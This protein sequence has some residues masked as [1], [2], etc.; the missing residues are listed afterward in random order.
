MRRVSSVKTG[1]SG[2]KLFS[3]V[4][5]IASPDNVDLSVSNI[6]A[7]VGMNIKI[8]KMAEILISMLAKNTGY[9]SRTIV[10]CND[11]RNRFQKNSDSEKIDFG[12]G[13][14]RK[15]SKHALLTPKDMESP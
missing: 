3:S 7:R 10:E 1:K 12:C 9:S 13:L 15:W 5:E 14:E 2:G 11:D 6:S 8:R 4:A